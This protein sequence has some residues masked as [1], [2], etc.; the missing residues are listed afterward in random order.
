MK[1]DFLKEE[2]NQKLEGYDKRM[3]QLIRDFVNVYKKLAA[4][5]TNYK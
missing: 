3:N 2:M 1:N 4:E 5:F